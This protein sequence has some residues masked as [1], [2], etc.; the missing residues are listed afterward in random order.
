MLGAGKKRNGVLR[1]LIGASKVSEG[2]VG[3]SR[4]LG[5]LGLFNPRRSS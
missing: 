3:A 5:G 4:A 1:D 2:L